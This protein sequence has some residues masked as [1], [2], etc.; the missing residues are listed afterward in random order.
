MFKVDGDGPNSKYDI[1]KI[2]FYFSI[3]MFKNEPNLYYV[4]IK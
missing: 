2:L 3:L 4:K 1:S